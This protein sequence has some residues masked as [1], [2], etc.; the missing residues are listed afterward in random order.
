MPPETARAGPRGD[1]VTGSQNAA[2][3]AACGSLNATDD[4]TTQ[5]ASASRGAIAAARDLAFEGLVEAGSLAESYAR[6]LTEAAWR[7]DRSTV[8]VHLR[9]LRACIVAAIDVFKQLDGVEAK[10][11]VA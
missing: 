6:S 9:Q 4:G 3:L 1:A 11:G 10:G 5:D 2:C 8:E 7:G